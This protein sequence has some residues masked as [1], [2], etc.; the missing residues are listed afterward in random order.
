MQ[1]AELTLSWNQ[2]ASR[3]LMCSSG[4][5]SSR[6]GSGG[7]TV[8]AVDFCTREVAQVWQGWQGLDQLN[9]GTS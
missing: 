8:H 6:N 3:D 7:A 5:L 9:L 4:P 1:S 2:P